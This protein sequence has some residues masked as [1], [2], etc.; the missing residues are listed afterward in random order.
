[1]PRGRGTEV[2]ALVPR[3]AWAPDLPWVVPDR[4]EA[5]GSTRRSNMKA[6]QYR[7]IGA[8][9]EVVEIDDPVAPPGGMVLR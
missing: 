9:P 3:A 4:K 2:P 8:E 7:K 5:A 1:M 6:V